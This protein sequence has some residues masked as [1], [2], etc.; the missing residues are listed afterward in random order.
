MLADLIVINGRVL[1]MEPSRPRAE[2]LALASGRILALGGRAEIEAL[3]G[4]AT[5][6]IDAG[7]RTV[8][9][10]FVE[11]HL[12]LG[13][14]GSQLSY[15]NVGGLNAGGLQGIAAL[16]AAFAE[17][18]DAN[19]DRPILL[20]HSA[21]Y[22]MLDHPMTRHDLDQVLAG[23]PIA[24]LSM[25]LHTCWANTAAL[26]AAGLLRGRSLPHGHEV[27]LG[28]DGFATGLLL[29]FEAYA[30]IMALAREERMN[31]GIATGDEPATPPD[32]AERALDK[33]RFL[34][35][36]RHCARHGITS[37]V[38]MDGNR[39]TLELLRE[40]QSEGELI[41][42][43]KVPFH[44][45]PS[46]EL[47]DLDRAE[48]MHRDFHD[49]WLRSGH[50]K[51][52]MDGV[53][54][55]HT[56][57]MIE[58]YPGAPGHR[59]AALFTAQDFAAIATEI[60]RR[61]LQI[62]VHC[63]GDGA[64]QRVLNGY[65]AARRANGPRDSRHRIEHIELIQRSDIPR[66]GQ[67][68]VVASLQPP[69]PPGAMDFP[70][71]PSLG[72]IAPHRRADAFLCRTLAEHGAPIAYASDWPVADVSIMRGLKAALTRKPFSPELGDERLGLMAVLHAY[73]AGGAWAAHFD[74]VTG[75]LAPGLAADLVIIDG[76]IEAA[77]PEA[78]D[79]LDIA[80]T[81]IGGRISWRSAGIG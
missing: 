43:V 78:L 3:A 67:L 16:S 20:A 46:H 49:D 36:L 64:V 12:H 5:Q 31:L 14:G 41:A 21:D 22:A 71:W 54:D 33:A 6:V 44:Y 18:A 77:A 61:G 24:L 53:I 73:T 74:D 75:R 13:I 66:L 62:A 81:M 32:A 45:K 72:N 40:I 63:C 69:H 59:G 30:P 60:D 65:E 79:R 23:R 19:P 35:G 11:S 10:G 52:F 70:L 1:T 9:P 76:D 27:V 25:D 55:S 50:V 51:L 38:M 7:G 29:E 42:R 4:P 39:Y 15:L 58:D 34:D 26:E 8:L 80:V 68:A 17:Y 56:A 48:A 57:F 47:G 2:A 37:M 28:R